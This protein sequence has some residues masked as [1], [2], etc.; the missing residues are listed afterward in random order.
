MP[1]SRGPTRR[2]N[3]DQGIANVDYQVNDKDRAVG[4]SII[5]RT[6]PPRI[7]SAM[8]SAL[9]GFAQQLSAGSQVGTISNTMILSPTVTWEAA[10][11]F[12]RLRAYA[13][14]EQDFTPSAAGHE[15]AGFA[16]VPLT[17]NR[18]RRPDSAAMLWSLA[19]APASAMPECTR[20][21]GKSNPR[22]TW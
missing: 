9:L 11:R 19:P 2:A 18:H 3:V 8:S 1:W 14:T 21:N 12:T 13:A 17:R 22:S 16:N 7:P 4:E 20:I 15:P 5:F 10:R 6:I